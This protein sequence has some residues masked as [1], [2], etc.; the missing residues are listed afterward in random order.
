MEEYSN[1]STHPLGH[2]GPVTGTLY[3]YL[4]ISFR[5]L[6]P[7]FLSNFNETLIFLIDFRKIFKYQFARKSLLRE[8]FCSMRR[9]DEQTNMQT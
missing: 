8:S 7:L 2:T 9:A 3:L 6:Y 1:T 5:V 4:Y